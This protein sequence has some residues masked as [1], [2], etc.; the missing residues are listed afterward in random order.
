MSAIGTYRLQI[1][2]AIRLSLAERANFLAQAG[3]MLVN[4]GFILLMWFMFFAGFRRVGGWQLADVALLLGLAMS[5]VGW[6][7]VAAGGYR[8]LAARILRGDLDALLTQPLPVLPRLLAAESLAHGWGDVL[9]GAVL[10]ATSAGLRAADLPALALGFSCGLVVFLSC[11]ILFASLAFWLRG[12]RSF[13]RDLVDFV[14]LFSMYPGSIWQGPL[15]LLV[16][17]LLPAGFIVLMPVRLLRE[18]G[19]QD[20]LALA[21][22][23]LGYAA[24]AGWVF[25]RGLRRYRHGEAPS[26]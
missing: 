20:A 15:K 2:S 18:P 17:T 22:A 6:A 11:G 19:W 23:A 24:L 16:H 10:L 1:T 7:N 12:A 14:V 3:G 21:G 9:T 26:A 13:T 25:Q 5:V 4:N 8:D